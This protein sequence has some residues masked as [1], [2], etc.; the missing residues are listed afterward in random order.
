MSKLSH[1]PNYRHGYDDAC[2][3]RASNPDPRTGVDRRAYLAGYRLA[4]VR[5][6][7]LAP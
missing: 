7:G 3:K 5:A 6:S 4:M 1:N 2:D